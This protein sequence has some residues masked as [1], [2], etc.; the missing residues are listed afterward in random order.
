MTRTSAPR[1]STDS[2]FNGI[3]PKKVKFPTKIGSWNCWDQNTHPRHENLSGCCQ[4][5]LRTRRWIRRRK[6]RK[7]MN[8]RIAPD[9]CN[10]YSRLLSN[11]LS[12]L[13]SLRLK[14]KF[15]DCSFAESSTE[16]TKW[17]HCGP[18]FPCCRAQCNK[19][20]YDYLY[21]LFSVNSRAYLHAKK[22]QQSASFNKRKMNK[23][24]RWIITHQPNIAS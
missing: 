3:I 24:K 19:N 13:A 23:K 18:C 16:T 8:F 1:G 20:E 7:S 17:A 10:N 6:W 2:K 5:M 14:L 15:N 12:K 4:A 21:A 9:K 22:N 11:L